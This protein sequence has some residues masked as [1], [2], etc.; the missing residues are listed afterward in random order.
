MSIL[1]EDKAIQIE[2]KDKLNIVLDMSS[3]DLFETCEQRYDYR[4]NQLKAEPIESKSP[5]LDRGSFV[6][7][8]LEAYFL[9][10][11]DG[12]SF[13][14]RM[15][16]VL[17][18]IAF[19]ASDPE[20]CNLE[21]K[22]IALVTS[23]LE[24]SCDYWR[25][26]DEQMEILEVERAFAYVLYEDEFIRII[27]T[28]KIDLLV[29]IPAIGRRSGYTNHPIDHKSFQRDSEVPELSNQFQNYCVAVESLELTV[30]R[31]GLYAVSSKLKPDEKFQRPL[32]Q[33]D[34]SIL[35][36]WKRNTAKVIIRKYLT[37]IETGE[38]LMNFTSCDKYNRRCEYY[39]ICKTGEQE[40]KIYKLT[41]NLATVSPWD[42]T[43]KFTKK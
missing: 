13:P 16:A 33:Y 35:N 12:L 2:K 3:F 36:Q 7:E 31:V 15:Q 25:F 27:I 24:Q 18:R 8:G 17:N 40:D 14:D 19:W 4:H 20:R 9:G 38:W 43:A 26:E 42:V 22:E 11:K 32:I 30:N 41:R 34:R 21:E 5:A 37:C 1:Y 6:H 39:D 28:G 29:N 23:A 10:I